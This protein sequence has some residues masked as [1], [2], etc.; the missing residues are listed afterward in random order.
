VAALFFS[1]VYQIIMCQVERKNFMLYFTKAWNVIDFVSNSLLSSCVI[2]WW[3]FVFKYARPFDIQLR[4]NVY[5]NL[6]ATADYLALADNGSGM[7]SMWHDFTD[8]QDLI[9]MLNWYFA[10]NGINILLLIAR[11]LKLM[12]FQPRL[13]VVTRSLWLAGP[14]LIHF[15]IVATMVFIGYS[16]M[17]HLIFGNVID[18]FATFG[19]SVNTCFIILLGTIDVNNDLRALPG[20]QN[21]AGALFFWSYELLVFMVLLN[22]LLAIIV[23]AFSEV[24][25]KTHET[26]GV[27]TELYMMGRDKLRSLMGMCSS[28]YISDNQLGTLLRQWAG[29]DGKGKEDKGE[30]E[31]AKLLT[32][33]N[34]D[35]DE[36]DLQTVLLECLKD[37]PP[38]DEDEKVEKPSLI[39]RMFCLPSGRKVTAT[40][41]EIKLAAK[42][43]V[44]RFGVH[45]EAEE[46][47]DEGEVG[48][49]REDGN[50]V[51]KVKENVERGGDYLG[52]EERNQLACALERLAEV[53]RAL[54]DGQ[55]NL[56]V[57]QKQLAE[58]QAKLITLMNSD[59][60]E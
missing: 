42:Y 4:Y 38:E 23:D 53:Q 21:V 40:A 56:M 37:A 13:G 7:V 33:L 34:E 19:D 58:Q 51:G 57:G 5:A 8:L 41:E 12:D 24:K 3:I 1:S 14:D 2:I 27:H 60:Q 18:A 16:M 36:E 15:F 29:E 28:N 45:M 26:V 47:G 54:A 59:G 48:Q 6:H 17:G 55:R 22:F 44:D 43:I 30:K 32:I 11:I 50:D 46:V 20:L 35:M 52:T 39:R 25:E 10:L 49:Q 31:V 9:D